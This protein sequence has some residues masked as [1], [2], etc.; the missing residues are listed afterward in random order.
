MQSFR[1]KGRC[2]DACPDMI[3]DMFYADSYRFVPNFVVN[4]WNTYYKKYSTGYYRKAANNMGLQGHVAK[5][6]ATQQLEH[7][8]Y[9]LRELPQQMRAAV[10]Y[11]RPLN[12]DIAA[13][14]EGVLARMLMAL[15]KDRRTLLRMSEVR[16]GM[17]NY[18]Y[19]LK[20]DEF[21][22]RNYTL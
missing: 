1:S 22:N 4:S 14:L 7:V 9:L 5:D 8:E 6:Y 11:Y 17:T 3:N 16:A 2:Q 20:P 18:H 10:N 12:S 21:T 19:L 13:E 15:R